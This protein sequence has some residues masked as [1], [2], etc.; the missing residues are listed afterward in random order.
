MV[1]DLASKGPKTLK[2]PVNDRENLP[3]YTVKV[4]EQ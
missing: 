1:A 4:R 3:A 2:I